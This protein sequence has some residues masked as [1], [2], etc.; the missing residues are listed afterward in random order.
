MIYR[1]AITVNQQG[2]S[3]G[4]LGTVAEWL[5]ASE[6]ITKLVAAEEIGDTGTRHL[7]MTAETTVGAQ[8]MRKD[9]HKRFM[10]LRAEKNRRGQ[11][12]SV[13]EIRTTWE[14]NVAYC[15]K[16]DGKRYTKGVSEEDIEKWL[17]EGA[18]QS[19][20]KRKDKP[21]WIEQLKRQCE[22][23]K[24]RDAEDIGE[25]II[26]TY[27]ALKKTVPDKFAL[28]RLIMTVEMMLGS[29]VKQDRM[30]KEL[31]RNAI[32]LNNR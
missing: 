12:M 19:V 25:I 17:S 4:W 15:L 28:N 26:K 7:Q 8:Q 22:S 32:E 1:L 29:D 30:I 13:A 21:C 16:D 9:I 5:Q 18:E 20:K 23:A 31:V 27:L 3:E 11:K 10:E 24:A 2:T 6:R 14:R